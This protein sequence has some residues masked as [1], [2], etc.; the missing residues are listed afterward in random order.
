MVRQYQT[1]LAEK[2]WEA[3]CN[4]RTEK[5]QDSLGRKLGGSC[6]A[7]V[8]IVYDSEQFQKF[9]EVYAARE[10]ESISVNG[11]RAVVDYGDEDDFYAVKENGEWK[12][13]E[14]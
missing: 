4:A 9:G 3:L 6:E 5:E 12:L 13:T 2:D 14:K 1:G 11:D 10:P 8:M 7:A